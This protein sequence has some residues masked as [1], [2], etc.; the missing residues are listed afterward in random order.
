MHCSSESDTSKH[1]KQDA[2]A[3]GICLTE[4]CVKACKYHCTQLSSCTLLYMYI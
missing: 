1:Q 3:N 2:S 4:E